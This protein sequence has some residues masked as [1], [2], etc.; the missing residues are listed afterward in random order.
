MQGLEGAP[1]SP[2]A[3]GRGGEDGRG[4]LPPS[5]AA[6]PRGKKSRIFSYIGSIHST[7]HLI[8]VSEFPGAGGEYAHSSV[9]GVWNS[10]DTIQQTPAQVDISR[11]LF[12]PP[13]DAIRSAAKAVAPSKIGGNAVK[14]GR[15]RGGGKIAGM[16]SFLACEKR[17]RPSPILLLFL[18]SRLCKL[19]TILKAR[20]W[21]M[22][23]TQFISIFARVFFLGLKENMSLGSFTAGTPILDTNAGPDGGRTAQD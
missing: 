9:L 8:C 2:L 11:P 13:C 1:P 17:E 6:Q 19:Q 20:R 14:K 12:L 7:L 15:K 10:A 16:A 5:A 18:G 22:R 23:F 4:L 3:V 21:T